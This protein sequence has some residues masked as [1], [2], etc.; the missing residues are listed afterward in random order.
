[1]CFQYHKCVV[2]TLPVVSAVNPS[3]IGFSSIIN[4]KCVVCTLPAVSGMQK[5]K[6][7]A[8]KS[9]LNAMDSSTSITYMIGSA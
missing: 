1:M 7:R 2:C 6:L 4:H 8:L 3:I 5:R 9:L